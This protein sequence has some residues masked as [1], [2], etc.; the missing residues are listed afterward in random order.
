[1]AAERGPVTVLAFDSRRYVGATIGI[2]DPSGRKVGR[3][4][5]VRNTEYIVV[6]GDLSAGQRRH[7][8]GLTSA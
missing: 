7:L 4:S 3:V 2:Y 8:R 5:H 1:M 6:A